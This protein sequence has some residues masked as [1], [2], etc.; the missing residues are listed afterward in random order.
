MWPPSLNIV[1]LEFRV[2]AYEFWEDAIQSITTKDESRALIDLKT[3][4]ETSVIRLAIVNV[5]MWE[6]KGGRETP[7]CK[8]GKKT[9]LGK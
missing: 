1:T 2:S 8:G 4:G 7:P 5:T 3:N 9:S 6:G